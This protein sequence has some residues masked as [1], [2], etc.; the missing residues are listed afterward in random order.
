M[1]TAVW[2]VLGALRIGGLVLLG[3]LGLLF[4]VLLLVLFVPVR[5]RIQGSFYGEPKGWAG[6]SW[7]CR[8][9][10]VKAVY[11]NRLIVTARILGFRVFR[12]EKVFGK[13]DV[14]KT[15]D[16]S[17]E[18]KTEIGKGKR[19][20]EETGAGWPGQKAEEAEAARLNQKTEREETE[21]P[22]QKAEET[23]AGRPSQKAEEMEAEGEVQKGEE[24]EAGREVQKGEEAEA[25]RSGQRAE[26]GKDGRR[27]GSGFGKGKKRGERKRKRKIEGFSFGGICGKLKEIVRRLREGMK[28]L[29]ESLHE[30]GEKKEHW[31]AIFSDEANQRTFRL[32]KRQVWALCRHVL[33]G[34]AAG[35]VRF[36]FEDPYITGQVLTYISPFYGLYARRVQVIPAFGESVMEG[37]GVL[38]GRIRMGTVLL[39]GIRMLFDR[40]FRGLLK[41]YL[42]A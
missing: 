38:K 16:E 41:K 24:A 14:D 1:L 23:E 3:I 34:K 26:A 25:E 39:I 7:L 36:G 32:L 29:Q 27:V 6:V 8:V 21:E 18:G 10:C 11:E 42:R 4:L 28:R 17:A 30:V 19:K 20:R 33:P 9:L 35:R 37:E 15:G 12:M 40:N 2:M 5:Y 13:G 31:M 22:S